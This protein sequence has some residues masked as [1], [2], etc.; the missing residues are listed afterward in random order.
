MGKGIYVGVDDTARK[1]TK[2][3]TGVENKARKITRGYVGVG[4]VAR[5]F[6]SSVRELSYYGMLDTDTAIKIASAKTEDYALFARREDGGDY[7]EYFNPIGK[8]LIQGSL[9]Y[10]PENYDLSDGSYNDNYAVFWGIA[11]FRPDN[12]TY[13]ES[14]W[15]VSVDNNLTTASTVGMEFGPHAKGAYFGKYVVIG[16]GDDEGSTIPNVVAVDSSLTEIRIDDLDYGGV[17]C[18]ASSNSN[19]VLFGGG[20]YGN[21]ITAYN[22]DLVKTTVP[23]Q[24]KIGDYASTVTAGDNEY[25]M[26]VGGAISYNELN[27]TNEVTAYDTNLMKLT[28]DT[29]PYRSQCAAGVNIEGIT[30]FAG[31]ILKEEDGSYNGPT[32]KVIAYDENLSMIPSPSLQTSGYFIGTSIG[33]F[34]IFTQTRKGITTNYD[35]FEVIT[36]I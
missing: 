16:G 27:I 32:D 13:I 35:K 25:A 36:L 6:F 28:L 7:R 31:G 11:G 34:A 15:I 4:G 21:F 19:Y 24:T 20:W 9:F 26:F 1:V 17:G 8:N 12:N 23:K 10:A 2:A 5:P 14:P 33:N 22:K 3:Y 29:L 30:L 18:V